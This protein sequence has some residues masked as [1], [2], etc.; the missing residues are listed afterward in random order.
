MA[1]SKPKK[2]RRKKADR[3]KVPA[4]MGRPSEYDPKLAEYFCHRVSEGETVRKICSEKGMPNMATFFAWIAKHEEF[5]KQYHHAK[6][7]QLEG[8][9][10]ETVDI[11]DNGANDWME[12]NDPKNP[13]WIA[14]GEA[15]RRSDLRVKTRQWLLGKLAPKRYGELIGKYETPPPPP[16]EQVDMA[17]LARKVAVILWKARQDIT[18]VPIKGN[19]HDL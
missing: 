9:A 2:T 8:F 3:F 6:E 4:T 15:V 17:A 18:D 7:V 16:V 13:G 1:D 5:K 14:N 19:G 12:R 11:A 10:D